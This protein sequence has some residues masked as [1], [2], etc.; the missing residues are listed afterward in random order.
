MTV[1]VT[2]PL[3][4]LMLGIA[5][6]WWRRGRRRDQK[7][8]EAHR[9][10]LVVIEHAAGGDDNPGPG[11]D[12]NSAHVRIL[13]T[14]ER[15]GS[16]SD[17]DT[18]LPSK[19]PLAPS[20]R[21]SFPRPREDRRP[22]PVAAPPG[23]PPIPLRAPRPSPARALA[24]AVQRAGQERLA[25]GQHRLSVLA[26]VG[27]AVL[28]LAA[29]V[30]VV[31]HGQGHPSSAA[32]PSSVARNA[33]GRTSPA[34]ASTSTT[35]LPVPTVIGT[36]ATASYA[37]YTVN[38]TSLD[39]ALLDTRACWVELRSGSAAGP[40]VY[41]GT[42][43]P[44]VSQTFHVTGAIWLRLGDPAG[45]KITIDGAPVVLPATAEPFDLTVSGPAGA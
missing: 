18:R 6:G 15:P 10:T 33:P 28:V 2:L 36:S 23:P 31:L 25:A 29:T 35:T 14:P 27:A 45:L 40:V 19:P 3:I 5:A 17:D 39:V 12:R 13:A 41:V 4:L 43:Q 22:E 9:S 37:T 11:P 38:A 32:P 24:A 21:P 26:A 44:G 8:I 20:R 42:L 7:S 1:L 16:R 30:G 34:R